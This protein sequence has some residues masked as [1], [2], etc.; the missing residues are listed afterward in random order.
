MNKKCLLLA[1][2]ILLALTLGFAV[3]G[4]AQPAKDNKVNENMSLYPPYGMSP[5]G[6]DYY[7]RLGP[8]QQK[9]LGRRLF[10][11]RLWHEDPKRYKRVIKIEKLAHDYR[12]TRDPAK[13][14]AVEKELRP[15]L[16]EELK[17][18]QEETKKRLAELEKRLAD[19]KEVLKKRDANWSEVVDHN[20]KEITGQTDYLD[21]PPLPAGLPQHQ[22]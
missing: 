8:R 13:K 6:A 12:N 11:E 7:S 16:D 19:M 17:A 3:H 21:F 14:Q 9:E 4:Q 22:K 5:E 20:F 15:L 2:G 1:A 10:L 18:Q